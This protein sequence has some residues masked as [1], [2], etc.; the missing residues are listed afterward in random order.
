MKGSAAS[1]IFNTF[2]RD[3]NLIRIR[4]PHLRSRFLETG[5]PVLD[6]FI[7]RGEGGLGLGEL[8]EGLGRLHGLQG[9]RREHVALLGAGGERRLGR[10]FRSC[11]TNMVIEYTISKTAERGGL[12]IF[13]LLSAFHCF[14]ICARHC[15]I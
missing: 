8:G 7:P 3:A 15:I 1:D 6:E 10:E 14:C 4:T 2:N 12:G 5:K 11:L 13:I 9:G